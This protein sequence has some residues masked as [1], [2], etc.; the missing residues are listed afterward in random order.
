V[1]TL[2]IAASTTTD[3]SNIIGGLSA[4]FKELIATLWIGLTPLILSIQNARDAFGGWL[5]D[6]T[7]MET[8]MVMIRMMQEIGAFLGTFIQLA[9]TVLSFF[10]DV[11]VSIGSWMVDLDPDGDSY[12]GKFVTFWK[13]FFDPDKQVDWLNAIVDSLGFVVTGITSIIKWMFDQLAKVVAWTL[14]GMVDDLAWENYVA[15][16]VPGDRLLVPQFASAGMTGFSSLPQTESEWAAWEDAQ[17]MSGGGYVDTGP[18]QGGWNAQS[19][20]SSPSSSGGGNSYTPPQLTP[21]EQNI[22]WDFFNMI[23]PVGPGPRADYSGDPQGGGMP[24]AGGGSVPR[25]AG[26]GPLL[27]GELGPEIFVPSTSG[28][29]VSNKDLNTRRTRSMLSDWRDRGAGGGGGA[30]VMTVGTLVSA[31][32]ISKNSKISIDSYAGVV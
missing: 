28:R 30:S 17:R 1:A 19:Q 7:G 24:M 6:V 5:G 22:L 10:V 26:G 14:G 31:N 32:S 2:G 27:V 16:T 9:A 20:S 4:G 3:W 25:Y 18:P 8:R 15:P 11:G 13:D 12:F 29:I 23:L 21:N